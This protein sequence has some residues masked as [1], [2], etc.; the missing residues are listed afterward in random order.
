MSYYGTLNEQLADYKVDAKKQNR[1]DIKQMIKYQA[2]LESEDMNDQLAEKLATLY[3]DVQ[4]KLARKSKPA[5]IT[6]KSIVGE[7][8][9]P[10][11]TAQMGEAPKEEIFYPPKLR[12]ANQ[13]ATYKFIVENKHLLSST[14]YNEIEKLIPTSKDVSTFL[15]NKRSIITRRLAKQN[16]TNRT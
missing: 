10:S 1:N 5:I 9:P 16:R 11:S 2:Y 12:S 15:N 4:T 13:R 7:M 3:T 14:E 6:P 8:V